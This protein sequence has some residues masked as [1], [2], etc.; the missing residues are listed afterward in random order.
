MN[1]LAWNCQG[2]GAT[3]TVRN[4]KE[5]CF[6][7]KPH[8][9]F[10][11][12]TKQKARYLRKVRRR[13]GFNEE[14]LVDPIGISGG[15]A[16]WWAD[17]IKVDI[18]FSSINII[19]ARISSDLLDVPS[20]ITCVYGPTD[21]NVRRL[22]WQEVRRIG[23]NIHDPW[24]CL[25][26]F[27]EIL[28]QSE[29][30]GGEPRSWRK[31]LNFKCLLA[32][33][34]LDDLGFYGSCFTWCNNR[35]E[36]ETIQE[37]IDRAL[38]NIQLREH[39]PNLQ[40]I[41]VDPAGSDHHLLFIQCIPDSNSRKR[42]FRFEA[43]W[44][45]H[46]NFLQV[47]KDSWSC[48]SEHN[49]RAIEEF[50]RNLERCKSYLVK[51]S[52]KE[53]PNNVRVI[54]DLKAQLAVISQGELNPETTCAK[55]NVMKALER[56]FDLEEQFWW[57]RSRV[58][59]LTVG[60]KNSR[61][62]H[63]STLKRRQRNRIV[64]IK[65]DNG[66]W[67]TEKHAISHN[68]A[69]FFQHLFTST[70]FAELNSIL[71]F[72]D[73]KIT[74]EMNA[75]LMTP[76]SKEEIKKAAFSLGGSKAPGPD[77][78]SGTFYHSAWPEIGDSVYLLVQE[79]FAGN[80]SLNAINETNVTL[81]PKVDRPE[82][83]S[84]FR[85]IGLCNFSYK[86]I[87]KLMANRMRPL[88]DACI[89]Q[90]QSAFIPGRCIQDNIIIAHEVYH[91][92][93]RKKD[94]GK[95]EFVLKLDMSKAYDRV[96]WN[97]LEGV[98]LRFSFC[99][100][101]VSL[102]MKCV[103]SVSLSICVSGE[104]VSSFTPSRGLRQGDPLSPYLFILVVE[105]LSLMIRKS[106]ESKLLMGIKLSNGCPELTHSFFT[107]DALL[108][109]NANLS[110]CVTLFNILSQFCAVSGQVI[111]LDKSSIFFTPNTPDDVM[112][113]VG[114]ILGIAATEDPGKYLGIPSIWGKT[115]HQALA[116]IRERV[117][118]K[119]QGWGHS[120]LSYAGREVMIKA[121]LQA[122][123]IY[124]MNCFKFPIKT[125]KEI[126]SLI[127]NFWWG[128][129]IYGGKI[130][131]KA[132]DALS[133]N[134]SL[135]GMGFRDLMVMNEALLAKTAWKLMMRP[136]D[137]WARVLKSI[138]FPKDEFV[139]VGKGHKASWCWSSIIDGR[140]FLIKDLRWDVG[141]GQA[142]R[143]WG[144]K[145]VP[146]VS[147][148]A[149]PVDSNDPFVTNGSVSDLIVD[150]SWNLAP[151]SYLLSE[152]VMNAIYAIPIP[153]N[154]LEDKLVWT[155]ARNGEYVVKQGYHRGKSIHCADTSKVGSSFIVPTSCWNSVWKLKTVPRVRQ[156][157][158]RILTRSLATSAA[159]VRRKRGRSNLC[160]IC[161]DAVEDIEHLFFHC[162]WTRCVWFGSILG[163]RID[164]SCVSSFNDWWLH[165]LSMPSFKA[166]DISLI[167]WLLWYIWKERNDKV[168]NHK[169]PNPLLVI[170]KAKVS[171]FEFWTNCVVS[172]SIAGEVGT[173][174]SPYV[175]WSPPAPGC[176]KINVDGA[177]RMGTDVGAI[178]VVCRDWHELFKWGFIDKVKS[179]SAF[180]TKAL[181]LKRALFL[182]LDL[183][184]DKVIFETDCLLLLTCVDS[185]SPDLFYW[186]SRSIIHDILRL[187]S[188][189]V[190]FSVAYTPRQGNRVADSLAAYA[191][192]EV[193]P[194]GW[195]CQPSP[196]LSSLLTSEARNSDNI[197]DAPLV[198]SH[199][200]DGG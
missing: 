18:L 93:R 157:L 197:V 38:G 191:Y 75:S 114:G 68:I 88:L 84:H 100:E 169:E 167:C 64:C 7:K 10:L 144:D 4:L 109:M 39:F 52:K 71:S 22:C 77:G 87:S 112:N 74:A 16:L 136:N 152:D 33:C 14:W 103:K 194:V 82:H 97:F 147:F 195:V 90:N 168:F 150:G 193:C 130:H 185:K 20:Y 61:F 67:L 62:F 72:I 35:E 184:H 134:K 162:H 81:I 96:E 23:R 6:R 50:V 111:N 181:A 31:I 3:L 161:E 8:I 85:P 165:L 55:S 137:L 12:E 182:A 132:W 54:E 110:N 29:K 76:V 156:F 48:R 98:L 102:I 2:L 117:A 146:G 13:C 148:P 91:Y 95:H 142:I 125:I 179:I 116:Y 106:Q 153:N 199:V 57:Q 138:Y 73:P 145:W 9:V 180:M 119:I 131:W 155:G 44:A 163:A 176:L 108:Y 46:A 126:Q 15:L 160:P 41:N 128:G 86:I 83:V 171:N 154:G 173:N 192:K 59:W 17:S 151:I 189:E 34:E 51:W 80:V 139:D 63:Q 53:F 94:G 79:F 143:I 166:Q 36:P 187:L 190:G 124:P 196:S 121:V 28:H 43:C 141:N 122:I 40:V 200:M 104:N 56:V 26:D 69:S 188:T 21:E 92:L 37:R 135:G 198:S 11:M 78:F 164:L 159:L 25:G 49:H 174:S 175:Q 115:K 186:K 65:D 70:G 58:N 66:N 149:K 170:E 177:F 120:S 101:W 123:P 99:V 30:E 60:D 129:N 89:S 24:L 118:R 107:D 42:V 183:G 113:V 127:A 1:A 32:D 140:E 158:W 27:N 5:E 133:V 105:V 178:G 45:V 47:V 172:S 19:H